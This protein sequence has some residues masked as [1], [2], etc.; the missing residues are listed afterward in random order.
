MAH[1]HNKMKIRETYRGMFA[2]IGEKKRFLIST[3]VLFL[4]TSALSQVKVP[5]LERAL[6]EAIDAMRG[7]AHNLHDGTVLYVIGTIFLHNA[8]AAFIALFAGALIFLI[9]I[10]MVIANGYL[11]GYVMIPRLSEIGKLIPHG[12]F[13]LPALALACSYGIWL[14]FWPFNGGKIETI[15][16]RIKQSAAIYFLVVIPLLLIAAIIEGSLIKFMPLR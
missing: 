11:I 13:E 14:G 10:S 12:I 4:L 15:K 9:P 6:S 8:V 7:M 1:S 5:G 3:A 16:H 2:D